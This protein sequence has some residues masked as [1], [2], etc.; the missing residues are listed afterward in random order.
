MSVSI[1]Q[2]AVCIVPARGGSKRIPD[3]NIRPLNGKPLIAY[4]IEAVIDSG[5][6]ADVYVSSDEI[7]IMDIASEYGAKSDLRPEYLGGDTVKAV[8]VVHEFMQRPENRVKWGNVAMCLPTCPGGGR[9]G[10][11]VR[12]GNG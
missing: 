1:A 7:K 9:S 8:E 10:V 11:V 3:K 12:A 4:T 5:C 2:T 6:F